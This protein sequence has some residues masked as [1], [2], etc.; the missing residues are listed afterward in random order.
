MGLSCYTTRHFTRRDAAAVYVLRAG[1]YKKNKI[2]VNSTARLAR[3]RIYKSSRIFRAYVFFI[4]LITRA[5]AGAKGGAA[6][7]AV[8]AW[9][10]ALKVL[11][12]HIGPDLRGM[13]VLLP[14]G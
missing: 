9:P 13:C 8:C 10:H 6:A 5:R 3:G 1:T 4:P 12:A 7:D 14:V 2:N 11:R